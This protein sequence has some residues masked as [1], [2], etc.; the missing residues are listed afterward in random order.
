M[1]G[2]G[3]FSLINELVE[4]L[5]LSGLVVT[6]SSSGGVILRGTLSVPWEPTE[7]PTSP[8]QPTTS[9]PTTVIIGMFNIRIFILQVNSIKSFATTH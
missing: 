9:G 8:R 5:R 7:L 3:N 6:V 2:F 1:V 4:Q